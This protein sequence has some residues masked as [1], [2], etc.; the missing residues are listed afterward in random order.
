MTYDEWGRQAKEACSEM[1]YFITTLLI[2]AC[3]TG[4]KMYNSRLLAISLCMLREHLSQI[5]RKLIYQNI[6]KEK[7][8]VEGHG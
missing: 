7:R 6:S 8:E 3:L 2:F 5:W 1:I 4:V